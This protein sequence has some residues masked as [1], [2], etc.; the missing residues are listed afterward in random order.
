MGDRACM[1]HPGVP[2]VPAATRGH[3]HAED[4][5]ASRDLGQL[6]KGLGE[7]RPQDQKTRPGP[8]TP[9]E[10]A[11]HHPKG[12]MRLV[13]PQR[14]QSRKQRDPATW[15]HSRAVNGGHGRD[16]IISCATRLREPC[17]SSTAGQMHAYCPGI[18]THCAPFLSQTCP[19]LI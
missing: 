15:L 8:H 5:S 17:L 11:I 14:D 12:Q 16:L 4:A 9:V 19:E 7:S 6:Q 2:A 1:R 18:I 10:A 13:A 3:S